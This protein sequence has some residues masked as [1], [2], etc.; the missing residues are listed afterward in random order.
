MDALNWV[1]KF[2][3]KGEKMG[4]VARFLVKKKTSQVVIITGILIFGIF[5][6]IWFFGRALIKGNKKSTI[7]Y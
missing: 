5:W 2:S 1:R 3:R 7:S 4:R 6:F